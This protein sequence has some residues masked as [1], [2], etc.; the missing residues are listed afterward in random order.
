[1]A[2]ARNEAYRHLLDTIIQDNRIDIKELQA[3][4]PLL[5]Q[6]LEGNPAQNYFQKRN[7][8]EFDEFAYDLGVNYYLYCTDNGKIISLLGLINA[9]DSI[10]LTNEK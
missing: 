7:E 4:Q 8:K 10:T 1:M 9:S 2:P 5:G 6:M 3:M